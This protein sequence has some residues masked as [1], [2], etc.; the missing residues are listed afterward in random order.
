M[1]ISL[2]EQ[3]GRGVDDVEGDFMNAIP[4]ER[5]GAPEEVARLVTFLASDMA[6]NMTGTS[7]TADGGWTKSQA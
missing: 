5:L 1:M 7:I 6:A 2:A 3:S 4:M